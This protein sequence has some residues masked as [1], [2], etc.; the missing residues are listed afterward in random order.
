MA[1]SSSG[2]ADSTRS[3]NAAMRSMASVPIPR[4]VTAGVPMRT[5]S[6]QLGHKSERMTR[7]YAHVV[8]ELQRRAVETLDEAVK[9]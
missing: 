4:V 2:P 1:A 9:R 5:I 3:I 7:R 8:P 6:A